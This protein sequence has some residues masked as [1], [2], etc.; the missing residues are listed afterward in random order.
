MDLGLEGKVAVVAASSRGL[1]RAAAECLGRE[2]AAVVI[3]G[4]TPEHVEAARASLEANGTRVHAVVADLNEPGSC[5]RLIEET[6]DVFGGLDIVI[7]NNGGPPLGLLESF[8]DAVYRAAVD[9]S[10][11]VAVRLT[12]ASVPHMRARGSGRIIHITSSTV[13]QL[14]EGLGLSATARAGVVAFSKGLAQEIARE[15]ITVNCIAPGPFLTDRIREMARARASAE[16]MTEEEALIA[17]GKSVPVGRLGD[18]TEFGDLVA[19]LASARAAYIT[20]AVIQIDG[21]VVRALS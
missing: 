4:R 9:A 15:G 10:L 21:G 20:G 6:V 2:G 7:T 12:R 5:E 13:K 14:I 11:M 8:D 16:D 18:P 17:H 19:F 1:G 3:N